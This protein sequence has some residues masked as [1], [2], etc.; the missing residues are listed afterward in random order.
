MLQFL[1]FCSSILVSESYKYT[2]VGL[3][4]GQRILSPLLFLC[5]SFLFSRI[6]TAFDSASYC[7]P[8]QAPVS[9]SMFSALGWMPPSPL[10]SLT[11][12]SRTPRLAVLGSLLSNLP[13]PGSSHLGL[14]IL[15]PELSGSA[16]SISRFHSGAHREGGVFYLSLKSTSVFSV[17][18]C[19]EQPNLCL[20]LPQTL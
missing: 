1:L 10:F 7:A 12:A 8:A 4:G 11:S 20:G 18:G 16:D 6:K 14:V 15:T 3:V 17:F 2:R 9:T 13:R 19:P 5:A